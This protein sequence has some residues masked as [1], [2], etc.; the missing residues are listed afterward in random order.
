VQPNTTYSVTV[1]NTDS[2]GTSQP[3]S[4]VELKSPNE[5]GEAEKEHKNVET[6]EQNT[7]T[8][9]LSPGLSETP[10]VQNMT[11]KGELKGCGGPLGIESGTYVDHLK[12]TEEVTCSALVSSSLEPTTAAVSL[13]V[14]WAPTEEGKSKGSLILPLSEAPLTGLTGTLEGGP[15]SAPTSI[16]AASVYESFT[17]G[18]TCGQ[19]VGKKKAKP[20]KSGSFSTGEVEF[21]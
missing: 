2:E 17:G 5:D 7:G 4:P 19:A 21:G 20:V 8:I 15:F 1:T 18:P 9:K 10:H 16:S 11:L 6:C 12:T 3:S 14:K 13:S